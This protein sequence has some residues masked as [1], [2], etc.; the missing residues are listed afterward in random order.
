[1]PNLALI[2]LGKMGLLHA[3]L[4]SALQDHPLTIVSEEDGLL[5]RLARK[6]MPKARVYQDYNEMIAREELDAVV[7]TTP[8]QTHARIIFDILET[9]PGL[10]I[11]VEE[12]LAST[13]ADA[14]RVCEAARD[15]SGIHMV[16]FQRRYA[17]TFKRARELLAKGNI[18]TPWYFKSYYLMS[19][20]FKREHGWRFKKET[21]GVMLEAGPHLLD[22]IIWMFGEPSNVTGVTRRF[23][24][25]EVEDFVHC[26]MGFPNDLAGYADISWSVRNFRVPAFHIEVEGTNG[27]LD[28]SDSFLNVQLDSEG[29]DLPAGTHVLSRPVIQPSVPFLLGAP[30]FCLE[31]QEFL[32]ALKTKKQPENDFSAAAKVNLWIDRIRNS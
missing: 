30:E 6:I 14:R 31:D 19:D 26:S 16:G 1:M 9:R 15:S 3:G 22:L 13:Y 23:V 20:I 29:P 10:S 25:E 8:V 7:I 12:P 21:G 28:V 17:A 24:S 11:F 18:G 2:G 5:A 27:K 4:F 32:S